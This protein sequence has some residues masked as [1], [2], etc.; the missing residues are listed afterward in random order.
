MLMLGKKEGRQE[1]VDL[2]KGI[3]AQDEFRVS[4]QQEALLS[5]LAE[6]IGEFNCD[7]D[8]KLLLKVSG[9]DMPP[10]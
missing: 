9:S 8:A 2:Q 1:S 3:A 5:Q 10:A 4:D 6:L 7:V